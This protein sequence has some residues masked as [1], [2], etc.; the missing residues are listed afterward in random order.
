[1]ERFSITA[2]ITAIIAIAIVAATAVAAAYD[3]WLAIL[4]AKFSDHAGLHATK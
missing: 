2:A 4:L 3:L 1:M